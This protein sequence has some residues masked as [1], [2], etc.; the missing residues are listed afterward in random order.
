MSFIRHSPVDQPYRFTSGF[1]PRNTG[2]KG[3][4]KVHKGLDFGAKKPN[5]DGDNVY[6]VAD[7][8]VEKAGPGTGYGN[9]IYLQHSSGY[10]TRYAHL[11][12]MLVK[13]GDTVK[14]GQVIGKMGK[15]GLGSGTH[16][17]FEVR[18]KG[19]A[20]DPR[21][22]L[23]TDNE[24]T[25][26]PTQSLVIE[27]RTALKAT[28]GARG[29]SALNQV[30]SYDSV[31]EKDITAYWTDSDIFIPR[32]IATMNRVSDNLSSK[33]GSTNLRRFL[34]RDRALM[35]TPKVRKTL[36]AEINYILKLS[37]NPNAKATSDI[38]QR[39]KQYKAQTV[40]AT[41]NRKTWAEATFAE[42]QKR[43]SADLKMFITSVDDVVS[44][45]KIEEGREPMPTNTVNEAGFMGPFQVGMAAWL[46]GPA[47]FSPYPRNIQGRVLR[48]ATREMRVGTPADIKVMA[49]G[50]VVYWNKSLAG[51]KQALNKL[52]VGGKLN[53]LP[54]N[55]KVLY[56]I[57]NQGAAGA[58]G[59]L[60]GQHRISGNQSKEAVA[61]YNEM[62]KI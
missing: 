37:A 44:I 29:T 1:G 28:P 42:V 30:L 4:S 6:A 54:R 25:Y 50:I 45:L 13:A 18:V 21:P 47:N 5:V 38:L 24:V 34:K 8:R 15:T 3:A 52:G 36:V 32:I 31:T 27:E 49:P 40:G 9:V 23:I 2:I 22:F 57:H 55:W 16:L 51:F 46:D 61:I 35:L 41:G 62:R 26:N 58:A 39:N 10:S 14:A 60:A 12:K 17:H 11:S 33:M 7:G 59:I 56:F 48:A 43:G 20:V 53:R 19:V